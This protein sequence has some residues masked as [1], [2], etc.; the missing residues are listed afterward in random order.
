MDNTT[1]EKA[2]IDEYNLLVKKHGLQL[3][4]VIQPKSYGNMLQIEPGLAVV[5]IDGWEPETPKLNT[6]SDSAKAS[7]ILND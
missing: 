5:E 6:A 4:A 3:S 1:R 7:N 2:F